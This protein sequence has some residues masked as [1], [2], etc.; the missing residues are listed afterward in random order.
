M[1][2]GSRSPTSSSTR[3]KTVLVTG[4]T[5]RL[6]KVIADHLESL[7][8]KV[9]RSSHRADAGA[10]VVADLAHPEGA[11][12]LFDSLGCIPDAIVNNAGVFAGNRLLNVASP[13]RLM[14]RL[15]E[16]GG[17]VVNILDC[18]VLKG[19][20]TDDYAQ[21]KFDLLVATRTFARKMRVN[22]VAPGPVLVPTDV[23]EKAGETPLGRPTPHAVA[24]AVAF[25]LAAPFTT[26]C[27]IPV[28]GGQ[29]V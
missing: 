17:T 24:E 27:V 10:D 28:D 23:S 29:S 3:M 4:G 15:A 2:M 8:W 26:G 11:D 16:H 7:G 18:R 20:P 25:L 6:G 19:L 14:E 13:V 22:A 21:D 12:L 1:C 9:L 5:T